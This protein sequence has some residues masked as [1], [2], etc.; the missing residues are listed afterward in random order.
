MPIYKI[1][2]V[3]EH[4]NKPFNDRAYIY[5]VNGAYKGNDN[6]GKLVH[7]FKCKNPD[8][9]YFDDLAEKVKF[10]KTTEEGF[11]ELSPTLQKTYNK[12]FKEKEKRMKETLEK[13]LEK[14]I[15]ATTLLETA[16]RMIKKGIYSLEEIADNLNL[17][18]KDVQAL[19]AQMA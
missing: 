19:S 8:E 9:F 14:K 13:K 3:F 15:T 10:L 1:H 17:P 7:D 12:F 2:R 16:K 11:M 5:Y 6:I 18:L 4:N